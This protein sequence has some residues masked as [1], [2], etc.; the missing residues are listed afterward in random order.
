MWQHQLSYLTWLCWEMDPGERKKW[1]AMCTGPEFR[2]VSDRVNTQNN[3][4]IKEERIPGGPGRTTEPPVEPRTECHPR[5]SRKCP[6]LG[7]PIVRQWKLI[8]PRAPLSRNEIFVSKITLISTAL[9]RRLK[10][11]ISQPPWTSSSGGYTFARKS[12]L[13]MGLLQLHHFLKQFLRGETQ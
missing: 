3:S 9:Q 10:G 12:L 11:L 6:F 7:T 2:L 1:R 4:L 5:L 13:F 8:L